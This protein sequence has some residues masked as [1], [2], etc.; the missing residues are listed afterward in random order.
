MDFDGSDVESGQK[1]TNGQLLFLVLS[2][3]VKSHDPQSSFC[4]VH[5]HG[6]SI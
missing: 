2:L 1:M 6:S 3:F 5:Y 4:I